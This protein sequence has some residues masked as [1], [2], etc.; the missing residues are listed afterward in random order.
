M[1]RIGQG[2]YPDKLQEAA[3]F[4]PRGE[5]RIDDQASP[6][7]R[8]SLMY[9]LS[10]YRVSEFYQ[11]RGFDRVRNQ[12]IQTAP[13]KLS[14][15]DEAFTSENWIVRI[16][17]VKKPDVLGRSFPDAAAF[18]AGKRNKRKVVKN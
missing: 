11:G 18:E 15:V 4:T 7:M 3:F 1:I 8:D 13:I 14:T 2:V 16:Y 17:K 9:K 10:Y 12:P 6:A 5:Y